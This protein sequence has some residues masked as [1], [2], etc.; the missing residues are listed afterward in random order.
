M[1]PY[2]YN[3]DTRAVANGVYL[4]TVKAYDASRNVKVSSTVSVAV[5]NEAAV[6]LSIDDQNALYFNTISAALTTMQTSTTKILQLRGQE[7]A[8]NVTI[9]RCGEAIIVKGGYNT[10]FSSQ[11]GSTA[12]YG[13]LTVSCGSA[14]IEN[15]V[16]R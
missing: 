5:Q 2:S 9:D 12:I 6:K 3:W 1:S 15:F 10:S 4:L 11:T 7:F 13:A 14:T 8:N 16:I